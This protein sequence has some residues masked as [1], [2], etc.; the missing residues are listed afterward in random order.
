[1]RHGIPAFSYGCNWLYRMNYECVC[2]RA[3]LIRQQET[4]ALSNIQ[5]FMLYLAQGIG[6]V[7]F[8]MVVLGLGCAAIRGWL[9]ERPYRGFK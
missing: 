5:G 2:I 1:M 8:V 9:A 3:Y 6:I 4:L 7:A